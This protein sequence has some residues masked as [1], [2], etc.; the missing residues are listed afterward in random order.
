MKLVKLTSDVSLGISI[1]LFSYVYW[2]I[3]RLER[4]SISGMSGEEILF[5]TVNLATVA[6]IMSFIS[7]VFRSVEIK[8]AELPSKL[9]KIL[10]AISLVPSLKIIIGYFIYGVN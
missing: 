6:F 10:L 2:F 8:K 4:D 9:S 3:Y 7:A 5:I 1:V